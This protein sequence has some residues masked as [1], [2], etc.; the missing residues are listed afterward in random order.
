MIYFKLI[1][2]MTDEEVRRKYGI[3]KRFGTILFIVAL[4]IAIGTLLTI[5][6]LF[7]AGNVIKIV[8][9]LFETVAFLALV[10]YGFKGYN[11]EPPFR[12]AV[13][14][15]G[16]SLLPVIFGGIVTPLHGIMEYTMIKLVLILSVILTLYITYKFLL[17]PDLP[18]TKVMMVA[19]LILTLFREIFGIILGAPLIDSIRIIILVS[20]ITFIY[21]LR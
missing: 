5:Y 20:I 6:C 7:T 8:A 21:F 9:Y 2:M 3:S 19:I 17:L 1:T 4:L 15:F 18:I 12:I 13:L 14:F 16:L 11:E 10:Y